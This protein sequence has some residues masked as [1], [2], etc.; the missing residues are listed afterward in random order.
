MVPL[1][2]ISTESQL[3]VRDIRNEVGVRKWMYTDHS[4]ELNEHLGWINCLKAD[5]KQIVFVIFKEKDVPLGVV[6][7]NE[8]DRLHK[9]LTGHII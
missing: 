4:I 2:E 6:N 9:K 1:T 7:V 8:I 3:K 5:K